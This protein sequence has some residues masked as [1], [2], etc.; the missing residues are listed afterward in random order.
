LLLDAAPCSTLPHAAIVAVHAPR[1][2]LP[3]R[4]SPAFRA[5]V[6]CTKFPILTLNFRLA[7]PL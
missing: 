6:F 4:V 5:N 2:V 3:A 7:L 1:I